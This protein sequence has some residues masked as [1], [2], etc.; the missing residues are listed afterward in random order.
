MQ[1]KP[2]I[3]V[4]GGSNVS[5][6]IYQEAYELGKAIAENGWILLNGG[7]DA[8]VMRASA[9][10][11]KEKNGIT[12][13]ILTGRDKYS[14]NSYIDI[15]ICTNMGDARNV[16]NILS[17][18][19]VVACPGSAGTLSEIALAL[20]NSKPVISLHTPIPPVIKAYESSGQFVRV[21]S[22]DECIQLV[23][24]KLAEKSG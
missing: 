24:T 15:P 2:I 22:V 6:K 7:R 13:G 9:E 1:R 17:S 20:K 5:S 23:K 11:A 21:H 14:A 3:G 12:I 8:G 18:D 16:I 10:G 19:I 4:M